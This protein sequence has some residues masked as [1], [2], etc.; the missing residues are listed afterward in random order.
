MI[1]TLSKDEIEL[2]LL[3]ND[4]YI[5]NPMDFSSLPS[6]LTFANI[7]FSALRLFFSFF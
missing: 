3:E 1:K 5:V 4:I 2:S 6:N 7:F